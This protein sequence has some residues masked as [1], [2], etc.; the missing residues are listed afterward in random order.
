M[1]RSTVIPMAAATLL[2]LL[3]LPVGALSQEPGPL[4]GSAA[5]LAALARVPDTTD[6]RQNA[7]SWLDQRAVA[8]ARPGA[9][10]PGSS[11]ELQGLLASDDPAAELWLAAMQG[12][13]S[14]DPDILARLRS[15][16][17][18]PAELGFDVTDIDQ[19]LLFGLPPGDGS[20]LVGTFDP[21]VVADAFAMRGFTASA[22]DGHTLLCGPAGCESGMAVHL[23]DSDPGLLFGAALGRSEPIA[24]S[25]SEILSSA[26]FETLSGMLAAAEGRARRWPM[27]P[28][29]APSPPPPTLTRRSSRPRSSRAAC[30]VWTRRSSASSAT[31]PR[32]PAHWS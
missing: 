32:R 5:L 13:S 3:V 1:R 6:A 15:A 10:Q 12:V 2:A 31:R 17:R 27:I 8:A 28:P 24:V 22:A 16:A 30:S 21:G 20:V 25:S 4:T 18:W 9:A 14:G 29:S 19:H 26:D 11:A 23:A 7:V